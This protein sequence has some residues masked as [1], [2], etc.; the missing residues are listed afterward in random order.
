MMTKT[1]AALRK[2][3][4]EKRRN[5]PPERREPAG[6]RLIEILADRLHGC[7]LSFASFGD[8]IDLWP[9]NTFL[10]SHHILAL[11]GNDHTHLQ[12]F[13]VKNFTEQLQKTKQGFLVPKQDLCSP[14]SCDD[15]DFVLVPALAFDEKGGRIGYGGGFYDRLLV[16]LPQNTRKI[17]VGFIEQFMAYDLPHE[18]HDQY[19][20]E[21]VLV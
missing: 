14:L 4:R 5:L 1:K 21:L 2:E 7:V 3:M 20:D 16:R 11:P 10:V 12:I 19:V 9:L 17:G 15:I 8:E 6:K 13:T 18:A